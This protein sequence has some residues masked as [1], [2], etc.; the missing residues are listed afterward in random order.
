M[1]SQ[2]DDLDDNNTKHAQQNKM[3][4]ALEELSHQVERLHE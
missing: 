3:R 2:L 4:D 1:H